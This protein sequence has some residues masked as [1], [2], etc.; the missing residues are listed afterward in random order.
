MSFLGV[1]N[2]IERNTG[3]LIFGILVVASI[4]GLVQV[5]PTMVDDSLAAPAE[6]VVP[7]TALELAGRDLYMRESCSTCHSQQVRPLLAEV[8]RY[9]PYSR[10]GEFAYDRPFLWGSKRTGPDL[11]RLTGKYTDAWHRLHMTNPRSVV[12][13][14]IMPAYP[15]LAERAAN[16]AGDIV[17]RMR[18]L[19]T[20]GTPYTDE[21]IAAA[22]AALEGKTELDAL[23]AYLQTLGRFASDDVA[24][25]HAGH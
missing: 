14:S 16:A 21:Q 11:H 20:L 4:G 5:L 9:G 8:R 15:W 2:A 1:H 23:I 24:E 6:Q 10:A 17:A 19:R 3:L 13:S 25:G 18:A 7:Y 22:P 12:P